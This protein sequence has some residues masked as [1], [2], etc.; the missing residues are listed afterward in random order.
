M[1]ILGNKNSCLE[2]GW[3]VETNQTWYKVVTYF[4]KVW[5]NFFK[6]VMYNRLRCRSQF[7][8]YSLGEMS[9]YFF[10]HLLRNVFV[11]CLLKNVS[12]L[13]KLEILFVWPGA[14]HAI[15][16]IPNILVSQ[17]LFYDSYEWIIILN[18]KSKTL[19]DRERVI[20]W[21][22]TWKLRQ[23]EFLLKF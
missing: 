20:W 9:E 18:F 14:C 12:D 10:A 11:K 2:S 8:F 23:K 15:T 22:Y 13:F 4:F 5:Y 21:K 16:F 19:D 6:A 3:K 17:S 1:G 7:T